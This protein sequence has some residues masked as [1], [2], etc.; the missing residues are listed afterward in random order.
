MKHRGYTIL[1]DK[2]G[3]KTRAVRVPSLGIEFET[4][5]SLQD[6]YGAGR[7]AIDRHLQ[8]HGPHPVERPAMTDEE[9]REVFGRF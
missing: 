3:R 9:Q 4:S 8:N 7:M 6:T 1:V 5:L 2:T